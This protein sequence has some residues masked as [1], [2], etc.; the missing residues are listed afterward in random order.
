MIAELVF[1]DVLTQLFN[2]GS[3]E[4]VAVSLPDQLFLLVLGCSFITLSV[5]PESS[6][7]SKSS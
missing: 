7:S 5:T 4:N 3:I 6:G 1:C 2:G